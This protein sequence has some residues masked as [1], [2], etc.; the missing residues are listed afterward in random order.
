MGREW[1]DEG[2]RDERDREAFYLLA[3]ERRRRE[4][5]TIRAKGPELMR[6][7]VAEAGAVVDE[8][9]R[10]IG[11]G[12]TAGE[13]ETLPHEG[14]S[15]ARTQWPKVVL[16][17]RPDYAAHALA[18]SM[19]RTDDHD[20]DPTEWLFALTLTLDESDDVRLLHGPRLF[21]NAEEAAEC[22]LKPVLFP[23]LEQ[24]PVPS[25]VEI[26]TNAARKAPSGPAVSGR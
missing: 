8:Y 18:C 3:A 14:F 5:S 10:K 23:L 22:L 6:R 15:L 13:Y 9:R 24:G 19:T 4:A 2:L 11:G 17:C 7:L 25:L 1:I 16:E 20:S 26:A 21:K 12:S